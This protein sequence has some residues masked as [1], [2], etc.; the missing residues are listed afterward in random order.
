MREFVGFWHVVRLCGPITTKFFSSTKQEIPLIFY[1]I[2][3]CN[4]NVQFFMAFP[5]LILYVLKC[6]I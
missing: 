6:S 1:H 5:H 4:L 2:L 3:N